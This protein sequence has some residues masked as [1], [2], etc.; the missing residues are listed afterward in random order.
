MD[1]GLKKQ[2]RGI[3]VG[4]LAG[5]ASTIVLGAAAAVFP[6]FGPVTGILK[7]N[8]N[9]GITTAA[10]VGDIL[11]LFGSGSCPNSSSNYLAGD[12]SCPSVPT[13]STG[14]NPTASVG[15]SAVNGSAP[16]FMRSDAAPPINL[17]MSPT[18][19]GNHVFDP[20][21]GQAIGG[22]GVANSWFEEAIGAATTGESYGIS[23]HA[24]TNASDSAFNVY[25]QSASADLFQIRGD[26]AI[27]T[28]DGAGDLYNVGYLS[29]PT[30]DPGSSNYTLVLS[31]RGK[32]IF[33]HGTGGETLTI[34]ESIFSAGD[35]VSVVNITG[36]SAITIAGAAGVTL[37]WCNGSATT[38]SRTLSN[39][40]L[41]TI[42]MFG[43]TSA[44]ISGSGIS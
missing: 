5:M 30:T 13:G 40:G 41:A 16:T 14:A 35:V 18:W 22:T 38:G 31:D 2:R 10:V 21:S 6:Y 11:A 37:Y 20:S 34:P 36:G 17:A 26:G 29:T 39:G 42:L 23:I 7:G 28:N 9:S 27:F 12:G 1:S 3:T 43:G 24:G 25:N 8:A 33:F 44:C 4:F 15:T 32:L 19:T